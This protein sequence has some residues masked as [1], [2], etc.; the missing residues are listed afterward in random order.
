MAQLAVSF[1][2]AAAGFAIGGPTGASIGWALA[3]TVWALTHQPKMVSP[4]LEDLTVRG[5]DYGQMVPIIF[6]TVRVGGLGMG[7]GSVSAGKNKFTEHEE[8]SG[9]KGDSGPKSYTYTLSFFNEI[10][11]APV[12][13]IA[14]VWRRWAN[15]KLITDNGEAASSKWPYTLYLGDTSQMP[16]PTMETI[17]G[18]GLVCPMRGRAY[19]SVEEVSVEDYG[20]ARPQVEYEAFTKGGDIP[21]RLSSFSPWGTH[22]TG[23]SRAATYSNGELITTM[24]TGAA[25]DETIYVQKFKLDGTPIGPEMAIDETGL[26]INTGGAKVRNLNLVALGGFGNPTT[27]FDILGGGGL[28]IDA[29][30]S[31]LGTSV[32]GNANVAL[33]DYIYTVGGTSGGFQHIC[34]YNKYGPSPT[35]YLG[36]EFVDS[37][38]MDDNYSAS[39]VYFG[40]SDDGFLY[41]MAPAFGPG[42]I[43]FWRY[44]ADLTVD[45]AWTTTETGATFGFSNIQLGN[46]FVY[47]NLIVVHTTEASQKFLRLVKINDDDTLSDYGVRLSSAVFSEVFTIDIGLGL[48]V[49]ALGVFSLNPPP[50][51][52][53]LGE[54]VAALCERA[55]YSSGQYDVTDLTQ[56]VRGFAVGSQMEAANAINLLRNVFFFDACQCDGKILFRNRGHDA[57]YTIPDSDLAAHVPGDE[58]PELLECTRVPQEELV[59]TVWVRYYDYTNDYQ[60]GTQYWTHPTTLSQTD[61]SID[62][63]IVLTAGEAQLIA[64]WHI[65]FA[66]LERD[67]FAFY[68]DDT[69]AKIRPTD[70][71]IVRGVNIRVTVVTEMPTGIIKVEGVRAF[72]G[73][74]T[75]SN[76]TD[77]IEGDIPG[78]S[79]GGQGGQTTPDSK[80]DTNVI[81]IDGPWINEAESANSIRAAI[82]KSSTGAWS[83]AGL[84]KS[85]DGGTTY[86]QVLTTGS[87]ASVGT[88]SALGD[89]L[90]G[91]TIDTVNKI[92]VVMTNGTLSSTTDDGLLNGLNLVAVGSPS[93]G[94][95][96]L[97]FKT[98]TLTNTDTYELTD[99]LRGRFGTEWRMGSHVV[100][101]IF[102][103]LSTTVLVPMAPAEIGVARKFK[104]VTAG[105]AIADVTATD[106]T[107]AGVALTALSPVLLSGGRNASGDLLMTWVPRRR[108]SGGWP[109]GSDLP[110]TDPPNWQIEVGTDATFTTIKHVVGITTTTYTYTAADQTTEFGSPQSTIHWRVAQLCAV[111]LGYFGKTSS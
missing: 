25:I 46:F 20:R 90:G 109:N 86:S 39:T 87:S 77:P 61:V 36:G 98:A 73:A 75:G 92:T 89:F 84:Y 56:V 48:G 45:H 108:G 32:L 60:S 58:K 50:S 67:R 41:V 102:V 28:D 53:T 104:A 94:W 9:G 49:D 83:G 16:D 81:L 33:G 59:R 8:D 44:N 71:V 91:N 79:G 101:E 100:N 10:C 15:G 23:V 105:S 63:P 107:Y 54:I 72:A 55:G 106:F 51:P 70:V 17:Y 82:Y 18:E 35:N 5:A 1:I 42:G 7:Q 85:V 21:W 40:S 96:F 52:V 93:T 80:A 64:Q 19:E 65:H 47:K 2:G 97:Q 103:L 66:Y 74:F 57:D 14:G 43:K 26:A 31:T 6:G 62:L 34:R 22:G 68:V 99:L 12:G 13:G 3:S 111:G 4:R 30:A 24:G 110:A 29:S 76:L 69:W 88:T 11:E 27:W 38:A 37:V 78:S 95:E